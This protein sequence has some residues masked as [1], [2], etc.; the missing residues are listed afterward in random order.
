MLARCI[1][2]T[3]MTDW[4]KQ[5]YVEVAIQDFSLDDKVISDSRISIMTGVHRKD[6]KRIRPQ[7]TAGAAIVAPESVN[8]GSQ[9]VSKWL[10]SPEFMHH[11]TPKRIPRLR[12]Q[13]GEVSFEALAEKITKDVRARTVLDELARLGAVTLDNEDMVTLVTEA[14]IP[15]KGEEEKTF[16]L[17]LGVGDHASAAVNNV[18]A[19]QPAYFDRVVHYNNLSNE[20]IERIEALAREHGGNLLQLINAESESAFDLHTQSTESSKRFS[21]GV[22]F[23]AEDEV[24]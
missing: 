4:L 17:G 18:L 23:F 8:L 5:L 10:G 13:G 16:Y 21:L 22:Y 20:A 7:I 6:V 3:Q 15:S 12:A 11:K 1:T 9:L 14:F 24:S 2:Y 19:Q